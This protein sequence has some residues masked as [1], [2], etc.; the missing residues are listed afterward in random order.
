MNVG[1]EADSMQDD[2]PISCYI[3]EQIVYESEWPEHALIHEK[4]ELI[5]EIKYLERLVVLASRPAA[6]EPS[7]PLTF[8]MLRE[9]NVGRCEES[10]HSCDDWS[11]TDWATAVAGEVGEACNLIKKLRRGENIQEAVI[12]MEIA[13]AVIYLDLLADRLGI[14]LGEAVGVK[15]NIVSERV[16]NA[17]RLPAPT[18]LHIA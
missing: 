12:A 8:A 9:Q 11:P 2:R 15:F 5:A 18:I 14:S 6:P 17:R 10:F 13:D 7:G 1:P 16:G 3:C 4:Q